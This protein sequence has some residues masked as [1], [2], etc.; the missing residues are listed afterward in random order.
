MAMASRMPFCCKRRAVALGD[1]VR[2]REGLA[3][4]GD[5]QQ[6]LAAVA[7]LYPLYQLCD[8]LRLVARGGVGR[9][10]MEFFL[11]HKKPS[12]SKLRLVV[13]LVAI[14]PQLFYNVNHS[15]PYGRNIAPVS[16][17]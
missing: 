1:D 14:I 4:A 11:C 8:G 10:Q 15:L 17:S 5:A 3:T 6:G 2:H 12:F 7:P 16:K 9:H 13:S